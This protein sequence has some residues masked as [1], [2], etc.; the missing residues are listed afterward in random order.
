MGFWLP[1]NSSDDDDLVKQM[2]A[3]RLDVLVSPGS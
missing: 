2:E 3:C 1:A